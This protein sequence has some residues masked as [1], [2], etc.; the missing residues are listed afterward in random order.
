MDGVVLKTAVLV[1]A[2]GLVAKEAVF[3][4]TSGEISGVMITPVVLVLAV[5]P[6]VLRVSIPKVEIETPVVQVALV[7]VCALFV[8]PV[9]SPVNCEMGIQFEQNDY[10]LLDWSDFFL[11]MRKERKMSLP[12]MYLQCFWNGKR[13]CDWHS[14]TFFVLSW[15]VTPKLTTPCSQMF[16]VF[17]IP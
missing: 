7:V 6:D 17:S 12:K 14:P 4:I 10:H 16:S 2:P 13:N 3:S 5:L 8:P 1:S 11:H 15:A 9:G